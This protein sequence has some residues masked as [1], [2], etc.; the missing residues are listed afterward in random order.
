MISPK[1]KCVGDEDS[2]MIP[3]PELTMPVGA[4]GDIG[5]SES[6]T[7]SAVNISVTAAPHGLDSSPS[8]KDVI[9]LKEQ[10][11]FLYGKQKDCMMALTQIAG[12]QRE[13]VSQTSL[14]MA[15]MN[16]HVNTMKKQQDEM[17]M[18][19][20]TLWGEMEETRQV[21]ESSARNSHQTTTNIQDEAVRT[22]KNFR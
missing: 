11:D 17:M 20:K 14:F 10:V 16:N 22:N 1:R 7:S 13:A 21:L 2:A 6:K 15:D 4:L 9:N 3:K 18:S 19:E 12:E 5:R 8:V